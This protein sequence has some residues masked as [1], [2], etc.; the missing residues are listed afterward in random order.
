MLLVLPHS[1]LQLQCCFQR[2]LEGESDRVQA[3]HD[4]RP[5][6][7]AL[8]FLARLRSTVPYMRPPV[9]PVRSSPRCSPS[10]TFNTATCSGACSLVAAKLR[11][12]ATERGTELLLSVC[13]LC[14]GLV[15]DCASGV[16]VE[17]TCLCH[18]F[19]H[20]FRAWDQVCLEHCGGQ[21]SQFC[22]V[23]QRQGSQ[24]VHQASQNLSLAAPF[25]HRLSHRFTAR[26]PWLCGPSSDLRFSQA[27]I[28]K[29][30][31]HTAQMLRQVQLKL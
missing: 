17:P 26:R 18:C 25:C 5:T 27:G 2:S 28:S 7:L 8:D 31:E 16:V 3:E 22:R 15:L 20:V 19:G 14:F 23:D 9:A 21:V 24:H 30:V 11:R 6:F 1:F 12:N 10:T 29:S 13:S 4:T